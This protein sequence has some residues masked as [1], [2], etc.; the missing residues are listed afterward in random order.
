VVLGVLWLDAGLNVPSSKNTNM[1]RNVLRAIGLE[2]V[3]VNAVIEIS[4]MAEMLKLE[5]SV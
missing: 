1:V 3:L 5:T 2:W 4:K